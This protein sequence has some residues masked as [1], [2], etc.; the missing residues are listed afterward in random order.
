M[1]QLMP[2]AQGSFNLYVEHVDN[3]RIMDQSN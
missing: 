2:Y 1:P 3:E